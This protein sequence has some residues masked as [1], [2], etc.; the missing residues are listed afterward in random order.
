MRTAARRIDQG[1]LPG[2]FGRVRSRPTH[3]GGL[4]ADTTVINK[5]H[6]ARKRRRTARMAFSG[7]VSHGRILDPLWSYSRRPL[8]CGGWL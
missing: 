2:A 1:P 7:G 5:A 4:L 8:H 6:V 3:I